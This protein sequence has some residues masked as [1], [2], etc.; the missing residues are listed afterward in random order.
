MG[1][2]KRIIFELLYL[3]GSFV[4][5]RNFRRQKVGDIDWLLSAYNLENLSKSVDELLITDLSENPRPTLSFQTVVART[6]E[7]VRIPICLGGGVVS[8][9]VANGL[10]SLGA[11]KIIINSGFFDYPSEVQEISDS[12]GKQFMILS[13]DWTRDV[14]GRVQIMKQG[15]REVASPIEALPWKAIS[16][17]FGEVMLKSI[18]QDGTGNGLDMTSLDFIPEELRMPL[19]LSGGVG[20]PKHV[21]EGLM[22]PRVSGVAT[23][24]LLNFIGDSMEVARKHA[25]ENGVNLARFS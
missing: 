14:N 9:L 10:L 3:E 7:K 13:L 17:V 25:F 11:D 21:I 8:P 12:H 20:K 24:N 2:K 18:E 1:L 5:S 15:G 6:I 23:A 22:A 4:Q 16:D 19:I